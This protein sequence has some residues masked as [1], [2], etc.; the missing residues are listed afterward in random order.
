M[1][2]AWFA[3]VKAQFDAAGTLEHIMPLQRGRASP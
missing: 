2:R 1:R 3:R